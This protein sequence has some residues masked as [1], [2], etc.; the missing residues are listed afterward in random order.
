MALL[1]SARTLNGSPLG[2]LGQLRLLSGRSLP[3]KLLLPLTSVRL[4]SSEG[5]TSTASASLSLDTLFEEEA[6]AERGRKIQQK[7]ESKPSF[8]RTTK[9]ESVDT[10]SFPFA[11]KTFTALRLSRLL[12]L[13]IQEEGLEVPTD[14]QVAAI[15]TILDGH[16][17]A[18]QSFTG[19]GKTLAYL[20]PI[21][22][23][24]GPLSESSLSESA[25]PVS[26][27][28]V[29]ALIVAPSRELAMQIVRE[30]EKMLGSNYRKV[31]QQ[32]IGGANPNRQEE[33]LKRNKP[34]IVVGTPGR[35]SELS[36]AGKLH[37]HDC[38]FL[39]LDEADQLLSS[40]FRDDMRRILEHVGR[41]RSSDV[42]SSPVSSE[43]ENAEEK[44]SKKRVNKKV[45]RQTIL[46]SATMPPAVL[47]AASSWG[48]KPLLVRATSIIDVEIPGAFSASSTS[49][50]DKEEGN[51]AELEGARESLPPNLEHFYLVS[52]MHHRV[53]FL[54][55]CIHALDAQSVIVFM[56]HSKRLKDTEYKL[57][58]RGIAAGSLHGELG[59]LERANILNAFRNGKL[60]VL[61]VSEVGARGLDVPACDLVVN[62]ELPTDGSHYAHRGGRTGRLGRKGTVISICEGSE[63]F[64]IEKF[65]KQLGISVRRCDV[66]EGKLVLW[67]KPLQGKAAGKVLKESERGSKFSIKDPSWGL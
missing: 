7:R 36:R 27:G 62:L 54:R 46:V 12:Q 9:V 2:L 10:R 63:E 26:Q 5:L 60:R 11:E 38:R 35:I 40:K 47:R 4:H 24:V 18:I 3:S 23:R 39:V 66:F 45:E 17:A 43:S 61:V 33:A 59:K 50:L 19:S 53:D 25:E 65:E 22:S 8:E 57:S 6:R 64:V 34:L 16:D 37:T 31:I 20:L 29:E 41:R 58:A 42:S 56:N 28:G 52:P 1:V 21:L 67:K 30:A 48:H 49:T 14:V 44:S 13:R 55:K 51:S 32:L 15:P